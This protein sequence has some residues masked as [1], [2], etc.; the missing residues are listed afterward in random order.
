MHEVDDLL[1]QPQ[2]RGWLPQTCVDH[3]AVESP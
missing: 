2:L 1:E 3:D